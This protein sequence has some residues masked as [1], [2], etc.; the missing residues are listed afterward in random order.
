MCEDWPDAYDAKESVW[1]PHLLNNIEV[2]EHSIIVGHSS[3]ALC[4]MRLLESQKVKGMVLVSAAHTD[5]GDEQER[6]SG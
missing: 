5:L 6:L 4:A 1:I 3:G 2:N